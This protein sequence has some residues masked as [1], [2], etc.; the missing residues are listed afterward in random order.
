[1]RR[2]PMSEKQCTIGVCMSGGGIRSAAFNLGALQALQER[3]PGGTLPSPEDVS[4]SIIES[5]SYLA[6]VSGGSYA[7]AAYAIKRSE[8]EKV[9]LFAPT[10]P[11]L[12]HIR[13]RSTYLAPDLRHTLHA[14]AVIVSGIL[15]NLAALFAPF[16]LAVGALVVVPDLAPSSVDGLEVGSST[17]VALAAV[18]AA[19]CALLAT[20]SR[21]FSAPH[22]FNSIVAVPLAAS[23]GA[24]SAY[25][26]EQMPAMIRGASITSS[27]VDRWVYC[28]MFIGLS[29]IAVDRWFVQEPAVRRRFTVFG[30]ALI[31]V[32][33][34]GWL[35]VHLGLPDR[36]VVVLLGDDDALLVDS[37]PRIDL[38]TLEIW[39]ISTI[40]MI[41][42]ALRAVVS[43]G[44][45][46]VAARV[47]SLLAG[48]IVVSFAAMYIADRWRGLDQN[49]ALVYLVLASAIVAALASVLDVNTWSLGTFYRRRLHH[50]FDVR[51]EAVGERVEFS[52]LP[53]GSTPSL[54]ICCAVNDTRPDQAPPGRAAKQFV[55]E[56]DAIVLGGEQLNIGDMDAAHNADV[57]DAIAASGAAV[58]PLM[59][60]YSTAAYRFLLTS[61]NV[62]LGRWLPNPTAFQADWWSRPRIWRLY[63]E[64]LGRAS[65]DSKWIYVTDGGHYDNLGL[66]ELV[67]R[68]CDVIY[69]FDASADPKYAFSNLAEAIGLIRTDLGHDVA[70]LGSI[71]DLRPDAESRTAA[72]GYLDL[73]WSDAA[74]Q[75]RSIRYVKS[76]LVPGMPMDVRNYADRHK[77]FPHQTTNDQ[78][79]DDQ[80]FEAYRRLGYGLALQAAS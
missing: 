62:R 13:R 60:R 33:I 31:V 55:F 54:L 57:F 44:R 36:D 17:F 21:W 19:V 6:A 37:G 2:L 78:Y 46:M 49:E 42:G 39:S 69:C 73:E 11:E 16:A 8:S 5:A 26:A 74:G 9:K 70:V 22:P 72:A 80:Q 41:V 56:R 18:V 34:A 66:V 15:L 14:I 1:M 3:G 79:F 53:T 59:G 29:L 64:L 43:R 68:E 32:G 61:F 23:L 50:A 47:A 20:A 27:P 52:S 12:E 4:S 75:T 58:S 30:A 63:M 38:S 28:S 65:T 35:H 10:S 67:R 48:P 7:A 25:V 45:A 24:A 76:T 51:T 77:A 40:V 71:E